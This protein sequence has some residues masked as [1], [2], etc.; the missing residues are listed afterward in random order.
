VTDVR[1]FSADYL[2]RT[3][4]GMWADEADRAALADCAL[5]SRERIVDVGAGTGEFS[6]VL[7]A[8]SDAEV[9]AVD[10]DPSLL[11]VAREGQHDVRPVIGDATR[12]PVRT[13]AADL[14]ACQALLVNLPA[15]GEA[16]TE[17]VRVSSDRVAAVEPHNGD[18]VVESTV[19]AESRL[20][21]RA[22]AAYRAGVRTDVAPGDLPARLFRAAGLSD[23]S[24]S[25]YVHEKRVKPP[26]DES[27]LRAAARKASGAALARPEL[28]RALSDDEHDALR[29][30]WRAMGREVV[31]A[32][33]EGTY[34]R[35]ERVP[36]DVTV[37]R[38]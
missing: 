17:F 32:M 7:A 19:D 8:E 9:A 3:R 2:E 37:G 23:V 38:V 29:R 20:A 27:D 4:E 14:V 15:P 22:R 12:L 1:R 18:V 28:E 13:D 30:D 6:A 11:S 21:A 36:F 10:A 26:Y 35:V 16:V 24:V 5:D 31:A 25:R 33:R 34:E